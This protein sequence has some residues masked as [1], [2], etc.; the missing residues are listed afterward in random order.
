MHTLA[1]LRLVAV[2][3]QLL[4]IIV[5]YYWLD[6]ALHLVPLLIGITVLASFDLLAFWRL[7]LPRTIGAAEALLH[8]AVDTLMMGYLLYLTGGATNPFVSLLVMPI[9]LAA[10]ALRLRDVVA[11]A[12]LAAATYL[13]VMRW[14]IPLPMFGADAAVTDFELHVIGMAISFVITAATLGFFIA[15]L[16]ASLRARQAD[17]EL[18]RERALRDEG[19]LAIAT[20]AAGTAHELNT[21]LSTIHT[22][23]TEMRRDQPKDSVLGDDLALLADQ[24]DRCRTIL[25]ELVAVGR[26][27]LTDVPEISTIGGFIYQ[28]AASIALLRPEIVLNDHVDAMLSSRRAAILPALRHAVI[29]LINNAADASLAAG[30]DRVDLGIFENAGLVEFRIRDYGG[31]GMREQPDSFRSSKSDGLGLG[32]ALA[33]STAERLGGDLI[34]HSPLGG[35]TLQCLRIPIASLDIRH[36]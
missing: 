14:H 35:G 18:E 8:I 21:P 29:N 31:S 17:A 33:N 28:C 25:R 5:V 3:G 11:V 22:L 24:A 36:D 16:A 34:A 13:A 4:T 12:A 23:L 32:L 9:T 7:R 27:Q 26:I 6:M 19:I 10:A 2:A 20:Q 30:G 15:R 1:G